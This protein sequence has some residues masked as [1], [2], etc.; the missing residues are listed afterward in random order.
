[1][2][3]MIREE[4]KK[5]CHVFRV[6]KDEFMALLFFRDRRKGTFDRG[7]KQS[8]NDSLQKEFSYSNSS[9]LKLN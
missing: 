2:K 5:A 3:I 1:M 7:N 4:K 6:E 8:P 9:E